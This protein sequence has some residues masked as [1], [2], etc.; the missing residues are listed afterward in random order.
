MLALAIVSE[1]FEMKG[2]ILSGGTGSRLWPVTN[3]INKHL[4][5]VHDKP[6]IYY[7]L[8]NL[9]LSGIQDIGVVCP[10]DQIGHFQN[11]LDDES[12]FGISISLIPQKNPEGIVD[13]IR[14]ASKFIN[15]SSLTV[16]LGD[17][18][19]FGSGF[20]RSM[21]SAIEA[22]EGATIFSYRVS[23]PSAF[24]VLETKGDQI[25]SIEE[26]PENPKGNRAI[27]GLYV[28]RDE[29]AQKLSSIEKS[30]RGEYEIVDLL[31]NYWVEGKLT[32]RELPRG[33]AWLDLGTLEDLNR[34]SAFVEALQSRQGLLVG[35]PEE[36][37][38]RN[39]W[40]EKK[41]LATLLEKAPANNY[42]RALWSMLEQN[43]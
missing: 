13:G 32:Q 26:K 17:N 35:S 34:A 21:N 7:P 36:A 38:L 43:H 27:T 6:M 29:L 18:F 41:Q 16:H 9:M 28:F 37:A 20:I 5:P 42:S 19:Y 14:S 31:R 23:D 33:S 8:T 2:L 1:G 15:G 11:L 12:R 4:L 24:G 3:S 25:L 39:G 10:E 30:K 22:G 40:I